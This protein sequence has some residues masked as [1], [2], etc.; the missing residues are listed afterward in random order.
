[1]NANISKP[2]TCLAFYS[3]QAVSSRLY[4]KVCS[5]QVKLTKAM[6]CP[7]MSIIEYIIHVIIRAKCEKYTEIWQLHVV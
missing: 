7:K 3:W 1:M 2:T 5:G 6:F 4:T